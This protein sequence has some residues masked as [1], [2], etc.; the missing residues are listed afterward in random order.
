MSFGQSVCICLVLST[1]RWS[2]SL[3]HRAT[4][5]PPRSGDPP[6]HL[7]FSQSLWIMLHRRSVRRYPHTVAMTRG[8]TLRRALG[9]ASSISALLLAYGCSRVIGAAAR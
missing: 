2:G 4:L 1:H 7:K 8:L 6:S 3:F 9:R 5:D